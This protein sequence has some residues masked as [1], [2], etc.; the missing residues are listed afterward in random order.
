MGDFT[1][2]VADKEFKVQ[3][4]WLKERSKFF[5][6]RF[7]AGQ[8][9]CFV[10][11][12]S[13]PDEVDSFLR[14]IFFGVLEDVTPERFYKLCILAKRFQVPDLMIECVDYIKKNITSTMLYYA[15]LLSEECQERFQKYVVTFVAK[16]AQFVFCHESWLQIQEEKPSL[17]LKIL[18]MAV[19]LNVLAY[20][21]CEIANVTVQHL[22]FEYIYSSFI[23]FNIY[24]S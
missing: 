6:A 9:G 17:A 16:H 1:I 23:V 24:I 8:D 4:E 2:K 10:I 22:I 19:T 7:S 15:F 11:E 12:D 13:S 3:K 21:A 20:Q 18:K 5:N 14:F